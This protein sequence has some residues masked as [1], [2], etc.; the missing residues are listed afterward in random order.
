MFMVNG[1]IW[2]GVEL[3]IENEKLKIIVQ[4]EKST[5]TKKPGTGDLLLTPSGSS[6][7]T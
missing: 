2:Q 4:N 3:Q 6:G 1:L 5:K 7:C